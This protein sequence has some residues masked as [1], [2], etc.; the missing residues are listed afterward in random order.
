[1]IVGIDLGTTNSLIGAY[2][3]EGPTL[4]PNASGEDLTPSAVSIDVDGGVIV[5]AGA[6]DRLITHASSSVAHFKRWMGSPRET[7]L[8]G[9]S[10]RPEQLSALVIKSLIADAEAATGAKVTEAVISVPAYFSDAQR[11]AT[12]IAGE[13]AGIKVERLINEPTAAALAYGLQD[14]TDGGRFLVFDLGGGTLDVSLIEIFDGVVEV[15]A[16]AGDNFLGGEDFLDVLVHTAARDLSIDLNTIDLVEHA[17]LRRRLERLKVQLGQPGENKLEITIGGKDLTWSIDETRFAME[18]E[19]LVARMRAPLERALRDSN[20]TPDKLDE[21]VLVGGASRMPL[22]SR[23]VSRLLGRLPLRHVNPDRAIALG[24]VVASGMKSRNAKLDEVILTDVCPYTLGTDVVRWDSS[25]NRHDGFLLP[26]I[27]RNSTVPISREEE[28]WPVHDDQTEMVYE[29]YQGE[30]PIADKNVKLGELRVPLPHDAKGH[31]R[32]T[33]VRFTYDVNG[34][35][36]VEVTVKKTGERHE[37]ILEQN[38]GVLSKE[39]IQ[40]RLAALEKLKVHPRQQQE[41][42]AVIAR[43]ERLYEEQISDRDQVQAMLLDFKAAL[44]TQDERR[45]A[46]DRDQFAAA[47]ARIERV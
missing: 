18:S 12:R 1:M 20:L 41:N 38:P 5:G 2:G 22:V 8:A 29:I 42:L 23:T 46:T 9:K 45:I 27:N 3:D 4:F 26:I 24:A 43:A 15:H 35:L 16:S 36:Q 19:A 25:G 13:L 6:R 21:V 37:L 28:L 34:I 47:L 39:D 31:E 44:E 14:R 30:N 7:I 40:T 11:N 17:R 33:I 32:S 10:L